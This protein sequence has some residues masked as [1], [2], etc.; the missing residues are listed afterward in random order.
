MKT[1]PIV[2][3]MLLSSGA[4]AD[5]DLPLQS[6]Y[7]FDQTP[8]TTEKVWTL[9]PS[10]L[11][12]QR[13]RWVLSRHV[14][15]SDLKA[16]EMA[17]KADGYGIAV[18]ALDSKS[19]GY[20][21]GP[22][23]VSYSE[24]QN[25]PCTSSDRGHDWFATQEGTRVAADT[26]AKL[27][28]ELVSRKKFQ[29]QLLLR[30]VR[31]EFP[32]NSVRDANRMLA[33]WL[34]ELNIEW[35]EQIVPAAR[36][37]EWKF[38]QEHAKAQGFCTSSTAKTVPRWEDLMEKVPEGPFTP[39]LLARAPAKRWGG[40]FSV[41]MGVYIGGKE[42]LG[43]FLLDSRAPESIISPSFLT[44]QGASSSWIEVPNGR[45]QKIAWS[46]GSGI[47]VPAVIGVAKIGGMSIP[48]HR[49]FL[50]EADFF[51][52]PESFGNCCDGVLG[53]DFFR[54]FVV[55]LRPGTTSEINLYARE[56]YRAPQGYPW[57]ETSFDSHRELVSDCVASSPKGDESV[58]GLVWDTGSEEALETQSRLPKD[59][60]WNLF[61]S[62]TQMTNGIQISS[63]ESG[64][65]P[66]SEPLNAGMEL[67]GR[68][69]FILDLG[70]GRIW[71]APNGLA[72]PIVQNQSG[73][74]LEYVFVEGDRNLKVVSIKKGS[75][76]ESL[77]KEGLR[78][79]MTILSLDSKSADDMDTWEVEQRLSGVYGPK[80]NIEWKTGKK[81][82]KIGPLALP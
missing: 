43:Q 17:K 24:L 33:Q 21:R 14:E 23:D 81:T 70:H 47:G 11:N 1:L 71:F 16:V 49:F 64:G 9:D 32:E 25:V 5:V 55:E 37:E 59:S 63:K 76:A 45:A 18:G 74:N 10:E 54:N 67:L 79:G 38:Y 57:V 41:R 78:P 40:V 36:A 46:G 31:G 7:D 35:K 65:G 42:L 3:F 73:L 22:G 8:L 13:T 27:W 50:H 44:S 6:N 72:L 26:A 29:L 30:H 4:A 39:K 66:Q 53:A 20:E 48:N 56:G 75:T 58:R 80:L 34:D 68:G 60:L 82:S 52:P 61:C 12:P 15:F 19:V 69:T 2:L 77:H 28:D 62:H 51:G